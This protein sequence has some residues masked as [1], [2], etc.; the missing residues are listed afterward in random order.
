MLLLFKFP[1]V[2]ASGAIFGL[3][4]AYGLL[5]GER[6]IYFMMIFPMKAKFFVMILAGV[7]IF[8]LMGSG[9]QSQVANLAHLG[10]LIVGFLFLRFW[11][12]L[13]IRRKGKSKNR[14]GL[15]LV[16]DNDKT[17]SGNNDGPKYWN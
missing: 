15:R 5:F 13:L 17:S 3:F 2:G 7:E 6:V 14:R 10:G 16:V 4:V 9:M 8:T 1:V 12:K 11:D